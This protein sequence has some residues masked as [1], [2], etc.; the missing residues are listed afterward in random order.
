[1]SGAGPGDGAPRGDAG[2]ATGNGDSRGRLRLIDWSSTRRQR[3]E[4]ALEGITDQYVKD[5]GR[6]PGERGRHGL[7]WAQDTRPEKKTAR[8]LEQLRAWWRASAILHFGQQL[9][10]G[11]LERCRAAGAAI[12]A[13][14]EP[15]VDPALAAVNVATVV[16]TVRGAFARRHVLAEARRHLLE[17]LRG[18]AFQPGADDYIADQ[19]LSRHGHHLTVPQPGRRSPAVEQL[20]YTATS[21]GPPAGGSPPPT[22]NRPAHRHGTSGPWSPASPFRTRSASPAPL[23]RR[24]GRSPVRGDR[25]AR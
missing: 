11:P 8:P 19:A 2:P 12:R 9:V 4:D 13:G 16:F 17:T 21:P 23:R 10:D 20:T 7:G 15:V 5:H 1:M 14:V 6:L 18:R 25:C 24:V 22:A 3:I